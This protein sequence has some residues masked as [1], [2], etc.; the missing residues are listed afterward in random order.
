MAF[1]TKEAILNNIFGDDYVDLTILYYHGD[2]STIMT[3]W[4]W[5]LV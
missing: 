3:I 5:R 2:I 1:D 4:K